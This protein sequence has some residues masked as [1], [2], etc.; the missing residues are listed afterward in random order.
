[1]IRDSARLVRGLDQHD[2]GLKRSRYLEHLAERAKVVAFLD[3]SG[4]VHA[5]ALAGR[6][7]GRDDPETLVTI[8]DPVGPA[9]ENRNALG[10]GAANRYRIAA[11]TCRD[12]PAPC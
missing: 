4:D 6:A 7:A 8:R 1:M 5:R 2:P 11:G 10:D 12:R 9:A 3:A